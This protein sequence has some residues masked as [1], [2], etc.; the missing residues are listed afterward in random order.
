MQE[1][2]KRQAKK[3]R[4]KSYQ[5]RDDLTSFHQGVPQRHSAA[6]H[7]QSVPYLMYNS[8]TTVGTGE[9]DTSEGNR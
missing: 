3:Q 5:K 4:L 7:H 6:F 1:N 2:L 9:N 8:I